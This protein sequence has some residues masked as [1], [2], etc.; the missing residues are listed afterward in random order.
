MTREEDFKAFETIMGF[1]KLDY[2][3]RDDKRFWKRLEEIFDKLD[4]LSL[5]QSWDY[6]D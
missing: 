3:S 6:D 1:A 4:F 5:K 2:V